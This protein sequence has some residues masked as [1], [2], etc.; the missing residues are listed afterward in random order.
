MEEIKRR[1]QLID[2]MLKKKLTTNYYYTDTETICL[3]FRK[4][5]ELIALA[6]LVSHKEEYAKMKANF[7][8]HYHAKHILKDIEKVNPDFYPKP[9]KLSF[10]KNNGMKQWI[11]IKKGFLTKK[12]FEYAYDQCSELMH[13]ENP[14]ATPKKLEEI[15]NNFREWLDKIARL[16][17]HHNIYL[18]NTDYLL[19]CQMNEK[20][21][22]T[23]WLFER[24]GPDGVLNNTTRPPDSVLRRLIRLLFNRIGKHRS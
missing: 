14:F 21:K 5:L 19:N 6:S 4:I 10:E 15:Y 13:A 12:E 11:P 8:N 20:G 17:E 1:C 16:L 24:Q 23:L 2:K 9:V 18:T 7:A 22:V 3:N